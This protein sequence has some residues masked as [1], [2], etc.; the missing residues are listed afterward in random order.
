MFFTRNATKKNKNGLYD[1]NIYSAEL[2]D[3]KWKNIME[4]DLGAKD[5]TNCHPVLSKDDQTLYFASNRPGGIGGM[6]I[7]KTHLVEGE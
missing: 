2:T 7:Y 4:I 6:D 3:G 1:L 5:Y